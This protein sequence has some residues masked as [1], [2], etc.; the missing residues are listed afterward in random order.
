MLRKAR[1]VIHDAGDFALR[2]FTECFEI[3]ELANGKKEPLYRISGRGGAI[4]ERSGWEAG[5]LNPD[6]CTLKGMDWR[7]FWW[8]K[9]E[10]DWP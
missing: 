8:L 4:R 6:G 5:T 9:A 2:N 3:N 10:H 7:T 1:K